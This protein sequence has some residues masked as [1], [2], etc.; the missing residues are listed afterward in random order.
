MPSK[1]K[2]CHVFEYGICILLQDVTNT[3][4]GLVQEFV[5]AEIRNMGH[6][7]QTKAR[8]DN[9]RNWEVLAIEE[10][11]FSCTSPK[12][13]ELCKAVVNTGDMDLQSLPGIGHVSVQPYLIGQMLYWKGSKPLTWTGLAAHVS[14]APLLKGGC[15]ISCY[16]RW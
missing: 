11:R 7:P 12:F 13:K 1:F 8:L 3:I 9:L 14:G 6:S 10:G 4:V 16:H 2:A 15:S 5:D